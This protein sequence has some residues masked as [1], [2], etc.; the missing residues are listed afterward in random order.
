M[1]AGYE[2]SRRS[3][4]CTSGGELRSVAGPTMSGISPLAGNPL[5]A[6]LEVSAALVS[7]TLYREA[8]AAVMARIGEAMTVSSCDLQTYDAQHR[9][10]I[11]EAYWSME[12]LTDED[13]EY[14]GTVTALDTRPDMRAIIESPGLVEQHADDPHISAHDLE[15]LRKWGYKSTLDMPL[16]VGE[17]VIGILGLQEKRFV[18]RFTPAE[19]D[20]FLRLCEL[21]AIGIHNAGLLRRDQERRRHLESL[22][23]ISHAL[24]TVREPDEVFN[25]IVTAAAR[26]F[27][28]PRATVYEFEPRDRTV[29]PR[30]IHQDEYDPDYDTVGVTESLDEAL[31]SA[32][33]LTRPVAFVENAS[34]P[35]LSEA[36]R[37]GYEAWGESTALHAPLLFRGRPLGMLLVSW[38]GHERL[39][40]PDELAL[41]KGIGDQAAIALENV[42]L[43]SLEAGWQSKLAGSPE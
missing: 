22:A 9:I 28:A 5:R 23:G 24:A 42:R 37:A 30:A 35:G 17:R 6:I 11:Y 25:L 12:G 18:R 4:A 3:K 33:L 10:C 20:Q 29:T 31:G 15:Q 21:A 41:A 32:A 39:V 16:R 13:R 27:G 43:R 8:L 26:A 34:D 19:R 14:L 1:I 40:T 2:G 38:T 36:V 7:S